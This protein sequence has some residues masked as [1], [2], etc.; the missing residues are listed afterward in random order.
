MAGA[1]VAGAAAPVDPAV[2]LG[3]LQT[4]FPAALA[5]APDALSWSVP[6]AGTPGLSDAAAVPLDSH[7]DALEALV[8][9]FGFGLYLIYDG[10]TTWQDKR[11]VED[12]PRETVRAAAAGRTELQGTCSPV[13]EPATA[14]FTGSDCLLATW[15]I[16][17]YRSDDDGGHWH[18]VDEGVVS[19]PFELD[20]GTGRMRVE[21]DPDG[22]YEIEDAFRT[23]YEVDGG[24]PEP[25]PVRRF[26][27]THTSVD[28]PDRD[29]V[30]GSLFGERR[31][32]TQYA[33]P[34]GE[35]CYV[36][37]GARPE[38]VDG[39]A[40][41][42]LVLRAEEVGGTFL[43]SS[44]RENRLVSHYERWAPLKLAGGLGL[45]AVCL[46]VLL[47]WFGVG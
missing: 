35:T 27:R 44:M 12:T 24:D 17:E 43:L 30:L 26:L 6:G 19:V 42:R 34:P 3:W 47:V 33:V 32:Y 15:E 46:Y 2:V 25:E 38:P 13:G 40:R 39:Q 4:A 18:T 45:S 7:G 10:F 16:E 14:P 28:V 11:L 41:Q 22:T 31:R 29:G 1:T 23:R 8:V 36:L 9:G 5:P 37:G 20:D 21:P